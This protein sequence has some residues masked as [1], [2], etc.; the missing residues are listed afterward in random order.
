MAVSVSVI[1]PTYN[2]IHSLEPSIVSVLTQTFKEIEVIVV[3]DASTQDVE[4]V[5]R[6][7]DDARLKYVRRETNGGAAAARNTGL[8]RAIGAHIAFQDSDDLWLPTKLA[9]QMKLLAASPLDVG[10]VVGAKI[11]YGRDSSLSYGVGKVSIAP[12]PRNILDLQGDQVAFLLKENRI[13]VQNGLF[14]RHCYPGN[15]WFDPCAKAN[16]DWEFAIRLAMRTKIYEH[17]DPVVLAFASPDSIS[18]NSRRQQIGAIRILKKNRA[19][20]P[21]YSEQ[22]A[23]IF[24]NLGRT[25][26]KD[27]KRRTG[28]RFIAAGIRSCPSVLWNIGL[29]KAR[30]TVASLVSLGAM[31]K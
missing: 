30:R 7:I 19:L 28:M 9:Q 18:R 12:N 31:S 21:R 20:W 4:S 23:L 15:E 25:L 26:Y 10:A 27:G 17:P 13:S 22:F 16:E 5:V 1:I 11:L 8:S 2:R 29:S 24:F 14:R 6:R 3:D